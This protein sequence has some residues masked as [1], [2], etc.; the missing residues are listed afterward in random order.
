MQ[1]FSLYCDVMRHH[2]R[3]LLLTYLLE[4]SLIGGWR[5]SATSFKTERNRTLL[6]SKPLLTALTAKLCEFKGQLIKL[7]M[8]IKQIYSVTGADKF[9]F[10][11]PITTCIWLS[12]T[13]MWR[14]RKEKM[15]ERFRAV[16]CRELRETMV[17]KTNKK[18]GRALLYNYNHQSVLKRSSHSKSDRL[19]C[20]MAEGCSRGGH[21][22]LWLVSLTHLDSSLLISCLSSS[23]YAGQSLCTYL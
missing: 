19:V 6:T 7:S 18:Q 10:W 13:K 22:H 23:P 5:E 21:P 9:C 15:P 8:K 14:R 3:S 11:V 20:I 2:L 1:D 4:D 16:S 17:Q 12:I